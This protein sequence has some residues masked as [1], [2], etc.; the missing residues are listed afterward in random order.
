MRRLGRIFRRVVTAV[1]LLL[2]L[3]VVAGWVRGYWIPDWIEVERRSPERQT[4]WTL[5]ESMRCD[6]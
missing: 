2:F 6:N 5:T 4:T 3:G 1:S